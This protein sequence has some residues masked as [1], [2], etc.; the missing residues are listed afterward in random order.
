MPSDLR[1]MTPGRLVP[2]A[3]LR[4]TRT[5]PFGCAGDP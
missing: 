5:F 3:L 2:R 4:A 1:D